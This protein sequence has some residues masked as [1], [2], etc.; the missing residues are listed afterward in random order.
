MVKAYIANK[1]N[2]LLHLKIKDTD[3][4]FFIDEKGILKN[5]VDI[6]LQK[7]ERGLLR[8]RE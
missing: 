8:Q 2:I 6:I 1:D 7:I 5:T 4:L 3:M